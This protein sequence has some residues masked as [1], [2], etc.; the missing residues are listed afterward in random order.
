M[1]QYVKK[2]VEQILTLALGEQQTLIICPKA[3][4]TISIKL[5]GFQ[6][7]IS[8]ILYLQ[9]DV[10][11]AK[12]ICNYNQL[13]P[14]PPKNRKAD[15]VGF[16]TELKCEMLLDLVNTMLP[17]LYCLYLCLYTCCFACTLGWSASYGLMVALV[18]DSGLGTLGYHVSLTILSNYLFIFLDWYLNWGTKKWNNFSVISR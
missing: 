9:P 8:E 15:Q 3:K 2:Y 6:G 11:K 1:F 14:H 17:I 5:F 7:P 16:S 10:R 18:Y 4:G 13:Y 12:S